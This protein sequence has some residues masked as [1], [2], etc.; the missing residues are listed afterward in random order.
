M[1]RFYGRKQNIYTIGVIYANRALRYAS[2]SRYLRR[3][4]MKKM[5]DMRLAAAFNEHGICHNEF[6]SLLSESNVSLNRKVL[7]DLSI[8]EPRTFQ[9]LTTFAKQRKEEVGLFD[10]VR[11]IPSGVYTHGSH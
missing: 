6:L 5:W 9:S 1:W 2:K 4:Y 3:K 10:G 7:T 8:Y 11:P